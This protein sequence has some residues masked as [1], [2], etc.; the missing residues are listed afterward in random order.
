MYGFSREDTMCSLSCVVG[1]GEVSLRTVNAT[2]DKGTRPRSEDSLAA[3]I[4]G[5]YASQR[6]YVVE[7]VAVEDEQIGVESRR[8][9]PFASRETAGGCAVRRRRGEDLC[10]R[11][12]SVDEV[13]QRLAQHAVPLA[14][15]DAGVRARH[16]PHS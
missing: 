3:Q 6:G 13:D 5:L 9:P 10:G 12:A 4:D 1:W 7:R 11:D 15:V 16:D 14:G 2:A 8:Q